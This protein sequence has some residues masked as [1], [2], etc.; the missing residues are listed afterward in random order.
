M[1]KFMI[2]AFV[3]LAGCV[4]SYHYGRYQ[5]KRDFKKW[6]ISDRRSC[7]LISFASWFSVFALGI[8]DFADLTDKAD[9]PAPW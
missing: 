9:K 3:Y 5:S 2:I 8:V 1:K 7:I 6:T 4:C